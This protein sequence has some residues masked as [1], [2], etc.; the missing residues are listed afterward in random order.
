MKF[1]YLNKGEFK[2]AY[3]YLA[4]NNMI[5]TYKLLELD[6]LRAFIVL[7]LTELLPS[8]YYKQWVKWNA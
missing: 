6:K 8:S 2:N 1:N 5:L 4:N 7:F 3:T